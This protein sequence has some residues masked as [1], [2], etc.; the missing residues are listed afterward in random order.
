MSDPS[1]RPSWKTGTLW[2]ILAV[3]LVF[4]TVG[5]ATFVYGVLGVV[6]GNLLDVVAIGLGAVV[7]VL[8]FLFIAGIL[9]R[10]DRY[11]GVTE[12]R[13]ELFE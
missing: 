13:V 12:R 2:G 8:A 3:L 11:R 5:A 9:Y 1:E 6:A 10:V 4:G 7:A